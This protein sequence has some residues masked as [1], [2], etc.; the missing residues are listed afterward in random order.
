MEK[1]YQKK[2]SPESEMEGNCM[3]SSRNDNV[4]L[5]DCLRHAAGGNHEKKVIEKSTSNEQLWDPYFSR[6]TAYSISDISMSNRISNS[7]KTLQGWKKVGGKSV[8]TT[9]RNGKLVTGEG[10]EGFKLSCGDAPN[11][12]GKKRSS[13]EISK[14]NNQTVNNSESASSKSATSEMSITSTCGSHIYAPTACAPNTYATNRHATS[15]YVTS[16]INVVDRYQKHDNISSNSSISQ[17]DD[18]AF[19]FS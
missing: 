13:H 12:K 19:T 3:K 9:Y 5:L 18:F 8:Y 10:A 1:F 7:S 2:R 4:N 6:N 17:N 16:T 14:E 11:N 15:T